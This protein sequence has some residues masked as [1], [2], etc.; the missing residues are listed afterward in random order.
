M[1]AEAR[2]D[3]TF[4]SL[5]RVEQSLSPSAFTSIEIDDKTIKQIANVI[6]ISSSYI[7]FQLMIAVFTEK[8]V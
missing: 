5:T 6:L 2:L 7:F 1:E 4:I 8:M 3:S